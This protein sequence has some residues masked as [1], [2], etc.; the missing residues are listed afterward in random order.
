MT[1]KKCINNIPGT[2]LYSAGG[3]KAAAFL[4]S[5]GVMKSKFLIFAILLF[6]TGCAADAADVLR[7]IDIKEWPISYGGRTRDP[8]AASAS[9]IWFVGQSGDYLARLDAA[10]GKLMR[11]DL[12]DA[13]GPHNL[14][15]GADGIVWYSGN[16]TGYIGRFDPKTWLTEKIPMPGGHVEDPHTLTFDRSEK[17]IWFTAQWSNVAGRLNVASRKVDLI[18]VPSGNA[19]PYGIIVAA[20]GTPWI[21][22]LGT[23][24]L[25]SIDPRTLKLT[26]HAIAPGARPRR[27]DAGNQGRIYYSDYRRGY[28]GRFDPKT[29]KTDEWKLPGGRGARPYALVVGGAM[30]WLVE[31]GPSPNRFVGFDPAKDAVTSITP[32]PSGAGSVRHMHYHK[33]SGAIW[34]GTDENTIGRALVGK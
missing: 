10:S 2:A 4:Q 34:F 23:D 15:V 6:G 20:N 32:I 24:K 21:A 12:P 13:P 30:V 3:Q 33:G 27:L 1:Y 9:Q 29:G 7:P 14:V 16:Q 18:A 28:L 22:L 26:E 5:E 25:A 19:R 17:H 31:T 11:H 8:F